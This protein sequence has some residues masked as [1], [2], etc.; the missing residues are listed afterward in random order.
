MVGLFEKTLAKRPLTQGWLKPAGQL[1]A[2]KRKRDA[3]YFHQEKTSNCMPSEIEVSSFIHAFHAN[4][5]LL[6]HL[7]LHLAHAT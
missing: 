3:F 6:H 4:V 7:Y 2:I 5:V 1:W